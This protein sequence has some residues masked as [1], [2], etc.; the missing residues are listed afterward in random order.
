MNRAEF[1]SSLLKDFNLQ[2]VVH[3]LPRLFQAK[4]VELLDKLSSISACFAVGVTHILDSAFSRN[5]GLKSSIKES[6]YFKTWHREV[7]DTFDDLNKLLNRFVYHLSLL[8]LREAGEDDTQIQKIC[9]IF[10]S[11]K[12]EIMANEVVNEQG[13]GYWIRQIS[14]IIDNRGEFN[15][16][17]H[18]EA[19]TLGEDATW[20]KGFSQFGGKT[21]NRS[22]EVD[23]KNDIFESPMVRRLKRAQQSNLCLISKVIFRV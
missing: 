13:Q 1:R 11:G 9:E 2:K 18:N 12:F 8:V 19:D 14:D 7:E 5:V 17:D 3:K 10:K 20:K 4:I 15:K 22:M 16:Y 21:R 6:K 23:T